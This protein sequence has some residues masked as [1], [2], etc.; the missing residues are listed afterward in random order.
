MRD[1]DKRERTYICESSYSFYST[2][3]SNIPFSLDVVVIHCQT[4][5]RQHIVQV[6]YSTIEIKVVE[7]SI[8]VVLL[9]M[10]TTIQRINNTTH[11]TI[12]CT[13]C[14]NSNKRYWK[15]QQREIKD[16]NT[17]YCFCFCF[18]HAY[19]YN[20]GILQQ[21][22][23]KKVGLLGR[24]GVMFCCYSHSYAYT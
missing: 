1:L 2:I 10:F 22:N 24:I 9:L 12:V 4:Y 11:S 16:I 15:K 6:Q 19:L 21:C 17:F 23:N 18:F 20:V 14:H 8:T 5:R 7:K 3:P 13:V